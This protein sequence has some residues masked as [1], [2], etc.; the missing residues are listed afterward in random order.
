MYFDANGT[1]TFAQDLNVMRG[2]NARQGR[3]FLV[4]MWSFFFDSGCEI[5]TFCCICLDLSIGTHIQSIYLNM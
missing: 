2:A 3:S 1:F 4:S 5:D